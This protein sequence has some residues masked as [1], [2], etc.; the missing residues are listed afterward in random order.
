[1]ND[2]L[3]KTVQVELCMSFILEQLHNPCGSEQEK[4][5]TSKVNRAKLMYIQIYLQKGIDNRG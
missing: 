5:M 3:E 1:M 2:T 4:K